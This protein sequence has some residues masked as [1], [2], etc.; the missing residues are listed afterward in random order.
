MK[1]KKLKSII[2]LAIF[3]CFAVNVAQADIKVKQK[4]SIEGQSFESTTLIKGA[5]QRTESNMGMNIVNITECDLK[6]MIM[7]NDN[8]R[9]GCVHVLNSVEAVFDI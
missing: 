2:F 9:N 7:L 6:R 4:T 1:I 3:L 5:R 8:T